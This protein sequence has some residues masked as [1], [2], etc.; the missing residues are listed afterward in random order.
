MAK[1]PSRKTLIR[2]LDQKV[3]SIIRE[4][5][6]CCVLCGS[7]ER[8]TN[9]HLFSRIKYSTRWDITVDG[10]CHGQCLSCNLKHEFDP[11]PFFKWY[12]N[13]FG[14]EAL[15]NLHERYLE[16]KKFSNKDLQAIYDAL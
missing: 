16:P 11:Y 10:N 15:D 14:G 13:S 4:R 6:T 8:L 1:V 12:L 5:D 9:G 2:K 3:S 7:S